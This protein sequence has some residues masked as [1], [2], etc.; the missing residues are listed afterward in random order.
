[1]W[2]TTWCRPSIAGTARN[3]TVHSKHTAATALVAIGS[4][5]LV[6]VVLAQIDC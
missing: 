3:E 4:G 5:L 2:Q 1:L 6:F